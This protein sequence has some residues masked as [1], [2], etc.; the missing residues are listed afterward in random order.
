MANFLL[1]FGGGVL[2]G[3]T[4]GLLTSNSNDLGKRSLDAL[5]GAG[6]VGL[7]FGTLALL[8]GA[9][10]EEPARPPQVEGRRRL[11]PELELA[12]RF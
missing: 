1:G 8:L 2:I 9:T 10:T 5:V 4:L 7:G 12:F 11:V 3:G 6:T